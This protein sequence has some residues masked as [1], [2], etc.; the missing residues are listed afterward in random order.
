MT[1][2]IMVGYDGS[3]P[4]AEAAAWAAAEAVARG[5]SL[6]IVSCYRIPMATGA[7]GWPAT[8]AIE[9][10]L[11]AAEQSAAHMREMISMAHP[12]LAITT[13]V[14]AGPASSVL[15]EGAQPDD[16]VVVG[17]SSHEG[18]GAFWLGSTPRQVI[19]HSA[20]PVVVVRSAASR[21][22]PDRIVV[23]ID[24][25][26]AANEALAWAV[27]EADLHHVEL[28]VVHAWSYPYSP[29]V[30]STSQARDL[31]EIDAACVLDRALEFA[32]ERASIEVSGRLIE[33]A[34]VSALLDTV[35]DGDVLVLGHRGHSSLVAG[36]LGS[37]VNAVV[38]RC[39]VPVAVVRVRD[40][41]G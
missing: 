23:G 27:A 5:A 7:Y 22:H 28:V 1:K 34:T 29:T 32:R 12:G 13:A 25:S 38:D 4:A 21:G 18:A 11:E 16:L 8:G 14:S 17:A 10:L 20:C 19:R 6:T 15:V 36:L 31:M 33:N 30:T 26:P 41:E 3:T 2:K 40:E 9:A 24:G 39:A 37:T 35:R